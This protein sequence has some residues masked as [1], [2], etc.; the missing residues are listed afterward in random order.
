MPPSAFRTDVQ[1]L[2]VGFF[3]FFLVFF[4]CSTVPSGFGYN[5]RTDVRWG[6]ISDRFKLASELTLKQFIIWNPLKDNA[7]INE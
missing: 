6:G 2:E 5:Q 3:F 7:L 1:Q 4:C